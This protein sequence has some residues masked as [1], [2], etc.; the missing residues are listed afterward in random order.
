MTFLRMLPLCAAVLVAG[1]C[2][3]QPMYKAQAPNVTMDCVGSLPEIEPASLKFQSD[4]MQYGYVEFANVARCFRATDAVSRPVA[5]YRLDGVAPPAEVLVTVQLS[6]GGTFAA[7]VDV[8]D[9]EF[10]SLRRYD[11]KD[12][13]RRGSEYTLHAFLNPEGR[14]PAYVLVAPDDTQVGK[15]DTALGSQS[16]P[17]IIPAGPVM[18]MYHAGSETSVVR[19]FL[20]GGRIQV[21]AK[22]QTTAAFN[23]K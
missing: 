9:S 21:T 19:P 13:V 7:A 18:F 12:F 1:G 11:F 17:V 5:L 22:P 20:A 16:S 6:P 3:T 2:A 14:A 10:K 8:L 23:A 4:V 15:S